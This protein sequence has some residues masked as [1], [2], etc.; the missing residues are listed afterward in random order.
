MAFTAISVTN[1]LKFDLTFEACAARL[2][3]PLYLD[4]TVSFRFQL[5]DYDDAAV[6]LTGA[7]ILCYLSDGST[8]VTRSS[9]TL[10]S[11]STYEIKADADQSA[12]TGDTGKG[13]YQ[14]N[15][16]PAETALD[17]IP[18]RRRTYKT[19]IT[20]GAGTVIYPH[21]AGL[22]DIGE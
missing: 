20:L 21:F 22:I 14:L 9:A 16:L 13:W 11:G 15:F 4:A 2:V 5:R 7:T 12:E 19:K 6:S 18:G 8:T 17:A 3:E 10:I 1:P